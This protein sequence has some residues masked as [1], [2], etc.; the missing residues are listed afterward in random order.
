M[1]RLLVVLGLALLCQGCFVFDEIDKGN[2]IL[3]KHYGHD[4]RPGKKEGR[5][6]AGR[7]QEE[8]EEPGMLASL[9]ERALE[10]WD[11]WTKPKPVE[12]DP[13]DIVVRCDLGESVTFTRKS[14]CNIRGGRVI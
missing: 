3:D 9:K 10:Q 12:R 13:D 11:E 4:R 6:G 14:D 5:A 8:E 1:H 2:E 7:E